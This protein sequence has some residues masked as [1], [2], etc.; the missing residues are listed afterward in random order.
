MTPYTTTR[1]TSASTEGT[2]ACN[3]SRQAM[4]ALMGALVLSCVVLCRRREKL[5]VLDC[6]PEINAVANA[7]LHGMGFE[8]TPQYK[9]VTH[10]TSH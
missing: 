9:Q 7:A 6:R 3:I 2:G 4:G 5:V 1:D 8:N 10:H